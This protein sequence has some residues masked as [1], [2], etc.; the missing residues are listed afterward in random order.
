MYDTYINSL[1]DPD[2]FR[3]KAQSV[4]SQLG[5]NVDWL[6]SVIYIECHFRA[7][8]RNPYTGAIGLIQWMP[9][10][11]AGMG[12]TANDIDQM[13]EVQQ[14]DL[15]LRYLKPY[16]GKLNTF[17]DLY[18]AVFYPVLA[19]RGTELNYQ[20][21]D[22]VGNANTSYQNPNGSITIRSIMEKIKSLLPA[23]AKGFVDGVVNYWPL[24]IAVF[25]VVFYLCKK[26]NKPK[27]RRR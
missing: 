1:S 8:D 10:T 24:G 22:Y 3:L 27:K 13:T 21:P 4:S 12:Y 7:W 2:G 16:K 5:I 15:V 25:G 14:L 9:S 17:N 26:N 11:L 19:G 20:L 6:Y 18:L 23:Q